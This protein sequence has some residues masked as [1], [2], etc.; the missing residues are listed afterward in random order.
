MSIP[1]GLA[2]MPNMILMTGVAG[3]CVV[4]LV[5]V[6]GAFF[7]GAMDKRGVAYEGHPAHQAFFFFDP[8]K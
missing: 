4:A 8:A 2:G 1:Y 5:G 6:L 7:G 3:G